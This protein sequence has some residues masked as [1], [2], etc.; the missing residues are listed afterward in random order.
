MRKSLSIVLIFYLDFH[1]HL[2]VKHTCIQY[3][4]KYV[5]LIKMNLA[6]NKPSRVNTTTYHSPTKFHPSDYRKR[7]QAVSFIN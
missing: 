3:L 1:L 7:I 5:K 6:S 2:V 4:V